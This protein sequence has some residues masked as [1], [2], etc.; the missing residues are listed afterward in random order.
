MPGNVVRGIQNYANEI[1]TGHELQ[2]VDRMSTNLLS[3]YLHFS[4]R[5]NRQSGN[6]VPNSFLFNADNKTSRKKQA[7]NF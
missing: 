1:L 7:V 3:H 6:V 5:E 2:S 4:K